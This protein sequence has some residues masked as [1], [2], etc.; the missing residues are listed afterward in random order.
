MV[1]VQ[2][3]S[4]P[5][6]DSSMEEFEDAKD[7]NFFG[8]HTLVYIKNPSNRGHTPDDIVQDNLEAYFDKNGVDPTDDEF[9]KTFEECRSLCKN[10]VFFDKIKVRDSTQSWGE[11][12]GSPRDKDYGTCCASSPVVVPAKNRQGRDSLKT[13]WPI[14]Y[15]HVYCKNFYHRATDHRGKRQIFGYEHD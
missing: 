14:V 5:H 3:W 2:K 10:C 4:D 11:I 1:I 6:T 8:E 15:P 9:E 13:A 7:N 12:L